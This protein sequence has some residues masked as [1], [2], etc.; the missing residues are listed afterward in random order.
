MSGPPAHIQFFC[1][2]EVRGCLIVILGESPRLATG[3]SWPI[4]SFTSDG[5]CYRD[6]GFGEFTE[7]YDW[8]RNSRDEVIGVRFNLCADTEFLSDYAEKRNYMLSKDLGRF[9]FIEI[10]FSETWDVDL[11]RSCDQGFVYDPVFR[12]DDGEVAIAFDTGWLSESE[13]RGLEARESLWTEAQLRL[14]QPRSQ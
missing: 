10:Y 12:S 5:K 11:F 13:L 6:C 4:T 1:V 7:F 2:G 8:L 9:K 3:S 14:K